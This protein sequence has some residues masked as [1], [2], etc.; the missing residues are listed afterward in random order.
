M[1]V[2]TDD[3]AFLRILLEEKVDALVGMPKAQGVGVRQ[4]DE[5]AEHRPDPLGR[6]RLK[7]RDK[8][9]GA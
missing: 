1:H 3:D 8:A 7:L 6:R 2:A 5:P 4:R 9:L